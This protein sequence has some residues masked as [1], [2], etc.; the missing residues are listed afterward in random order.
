MEIVEAAG[1][2][3][4]GKVR[5]ARREHFDEAVRELEGRDVL[6]T[7]RRARAAR[8]TKQNAYLWSTVYSYVSEHT[9]YT[10]EEVHEWAK[11]RF[12]PKSLAFADG[13]GVVVE[14]LVVGGSTTRLNTAEMTD[15]IEAVRTFARENLN[16]II[17]DPSETW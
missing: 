4:G 10:V 15:Y 9:G 2:I 6:I 7:V 8:S 1:R 11:C 13:N 17:P 12:L 16:V 5:L 3:E 14:E